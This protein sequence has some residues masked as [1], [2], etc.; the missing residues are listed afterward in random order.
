MKNMDELSLSTSVFG[1]EYGPGKRLPDYIELAQKAGFSMIELSRR[2]HAGTLDSL[3]GIRKS[4]I[5]VWSVHG[6]M[7]GHCV[8]SDEALRRKAVEAAYRRAAECAEFAPC[9][10]VEHYMFRYNDPAYGVSFRKS[11]EELYEKVS[12]LGFILCIETAPYKP[13]ENERYPESAEIAAF[14]RSFDLDYLQMTVDI[15]HSNIHENLLDVAAN[16]RGLVKN[17]HVSNN[18]GAWEDHLP[19]DHPEGVIDIRQ[20]FEALRANGY[21]GPCNLEFKFPAFPETPSVEDLCTVRIHVEQRLWNK[22]DLK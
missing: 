18:R 17:I 4:G 22:K 7:N 5:K 12:P 3:E 16:T 14:V 19:P 9:P 13:K 6:I 11:I 15:N 8:S 20:T 1:A 10:L 21:T 2:Q